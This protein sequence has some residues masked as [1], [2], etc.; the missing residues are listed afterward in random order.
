MK[1]I[2][3]IVLI[4]VIV[5]IIF[6]IISS[7]RRHK[8]VKLIED[9]DEIKGITINYV[10]V[11]KIIKEK[12][13]LDILEKYSCKY[14]RKNFEYDSSINIIYEINYNE[15][16]KIRHILLG[17][18]NIYYESNENSYEIINGDELL[19]ELVKVLE[20]DDVK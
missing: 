9:R 20:D 10:P 8:E 19:N 4:F 3:K 12:K 11:K 14:Y 1:G 17:D 18:I 7:V 16:N 6:I 13:L 15:G 2:L 5:V